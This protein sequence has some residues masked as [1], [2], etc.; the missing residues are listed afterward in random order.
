MV[1]ADRRSSRAPQLPRMPRNARTNRHAAIVAV[2][3]RCEANWPRD[4]G[5]ASRSR[6]HRG[7]RGLRSKLAIPDVD[8]STRRRVGTLGRESPW[9]DVELGR[10]D[11]ERFSLAVAGRRAL[12]EVVR[13]LADNLPA[14]DAAAVEVM[15]DRCPGDAESCGQRVDRRP[16]RRSAGRG[17]RRSPRT[18]GAGQGLK[19]VPLGLEPRPTRPPRPSFV[20][21]RRPSVGPAGPLT[22]VLQGFPRPGEGLKAVPKGPRPRSCVV[23][24]PLRLTIHPRPGARR[25]GRAVRSMAATECARRRLKESRS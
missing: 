2:L 1:S 14:P 7:R 19:A 25:R 16:P 5:T 3:I 12:D 4:A 17:R 21:H 18:A 8:G 6:G 13:H 11:L 24:S 9:V 10:N 20:A 15:D 22:P 23:P